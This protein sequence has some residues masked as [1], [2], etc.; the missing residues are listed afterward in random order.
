MIARY[1]ILGAAALF[2]LSLASFSPA[3]AA[4]GSN[5]AVTAQQAETIQ[6]AAGHGGG[7]MKK[8]EKK[9]KKKKSQ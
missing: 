6:M 2:A 5:T 7:D 3:S 8:E 1:M 9:K 4:Q